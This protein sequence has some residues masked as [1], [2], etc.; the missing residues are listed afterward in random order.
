[1][2][3]RVRLKFVCFI[4]LQLFPLCFGNNEDEKVI[5]L[6]LFK[7]V[8][9]PQ[10]TVWVRRG[11]TVLLPCSGFSAD[12]ATVEVQWHRNNIPLSSAK[13]LSDNVGS[14][15]HKI[16]PD[17]NN[18]TS[19]P[20]NQRRF[21]RFSQQ[22]NGSLLIH[23]VFTSGFYQCFISSGQQRLAS[24]RCTLNLYGP[25]TDSVPVNQHSASDGD[26]V[27]FYFYPT[28]PAYA[29]HKNKHNLPQDKRYL[30]L[31][32]VLQIL[33]VTSSDSGLYSY[34]VSP[35]SAA[36]KQVYLNVERKIGTR[37]F[38]WVNVTDE[39]EVEEGSELI[40][41]CLASNS[42]LITYQWL[43]NNNSPFCNMSVGC[44]MENGN[45]RMVNT[46]LDHNGVY[47]CIATSNGNSHTRKTHVIVYKKPSISVDPSHYSWRTPS[48]IEIIQCDVKAF[49]SPTQVFWMKNGKRVA[50][51]GE[52][53][54]NPRLFAAKKFWEVVLEAKHVKPEFRGL[55]QCVAENKYGYSISTVNVTLTK[56]DFLPPV[57]NVTA[58]NVTANSVLVSFLSTEE[59]HLILWTSDRTTETGEAVLKNDLLVCPLTGETSPNHCKRNVTGLEA[60]TNY[61]FWVQSVTKIPS[62]EAGPIFVRTAECVPGT[63]ATKREGV[64]VLGPTDLV[65]SWEPITGAKSCGRI[66]FYK[67]EYFALGVAGEAKSTTV[68]VTDEM[69]SSKYLFA[70][71]RSL[72][73]D[74]EYHFSILPATRLGCFQGKNGGDTGTREAIKTPAT[75]QQPQCD[76]IS[77]H[78]SVQAEFENISS[79]NLLVKWGIPHSSPVARFKL[80]VHNYEK[81][82]IL[83][84]FVGAASENF[85]IPS[86][87]RSVMYKVTLQS[88]H[89]TNATCLNVSTAI[90]P[91][92][93]CDVS[94]PKMSVMRV[95]M[96]EIEVGW[97]YN[98]E[99]YP[100]QPINYYQVR[101]SSQSEG[102]KYINS[103]DNKVEIVGLQP[104]TLYDVS[105]R[106]VFREIVAGRKSSPFSTSSLRVWT[107]PV[108]LEPP[109]VLYVTKGNQTIQFSWTK[110]NQTEKILHYMLQYNCSYDGQLVASNT[111]NVPAE[112][113][114]NF[115]LSVPC[116]WFDGECVVEVAAVN[117][118]GPGKFKQ[119]TFPLNKFC[120][121]TVIS[122]TTAPP[123]DNSTVVAIIVGVLISMLFLLLI[124]LLLMCF[125]RED[126]FEWLKCIW[127]KES[128]T[129]LRHCNA[130]HPNSRSSN[131]YN[132]D[133][134]VGVDTT[135]LSTPHTNGF[136]AN[137]HA[138]P[139][140]NGVSK[141]IPS[142]E[143]KTHTKPLSSNGV[144]NTHWGINSTRL[145]FN[146]NLKP[147]NN[148]AAQ[149]N[150]NNC[151]PPHTSIP[152]PKH[153]K[154][155]RQTS[156]ELS[157]SDTSPGLDDDVD[158]TFPTT[159]SLF[160]EIESLMKQK[161][162]SGNLAS[163]NSGDEMT[164]FD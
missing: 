31:P 130:H 69:R 52:E 67:V 37:D 48:N 41:E 153:S 129:S 9:E 42:H 112:Q 147:G 11:G 7:F 133:V 158:L 89:S 87:S 93:H 27:R 90:F 5:P 72:K 125:C 38:T 4:F 116:M 49:P 154:L 131:H 128:A 150:R 80:L 163:S 85:S 12:A 15:N 59:R 156:R 73:P 28:P 53:D 63:Y 77:Q 111:E 10:P 118:R 70:Q 65:V 75:P 62:I 101:Y 71:L 39:V 145:F 57:K 102:V 98:P 74:T 134:Q 51:S 79:G 17:L 123:S 32:G 86:L 151:L 121:R 149:A 21:E 142:Y 106:V 126:M 50:F 45:L 61:T 33:N 152:I 76:P 19:I 117:R 66:I 36:L 132:P 40:L 94:A 122:S 46:T 119:K 164:N 127:C 81:D 120:S 82:L 137:G 115:F 3:S 160:S 105:T 1:M 104:D 139:Q 25:P 161:S 8:D 135:L 113:K 146:K 97:E 35:D 58:S 84:K 162:F 100:D 99:W 60:F 20:H 55:Y 13:P 107:L 88:F 95:G 29:W 68:Q 109:H 6:P 23:S 148:S 26:C 103:T 54:F 22:N 144:N 78:F 83:E 96:N 155:M 16:S 56:Y 43:D 136:I 2:T 141:H 124:G 14:L 34:R 44:R 140:R 92:A 114:D 138:H 30:L 108:I 143:M 47:T 157:V 159:T 110:P 64:V 18:E 91:G 24:Q